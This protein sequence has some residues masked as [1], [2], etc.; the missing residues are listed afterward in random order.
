MN[1]ILITDDVPVIIAKMSDGDALI[2]N[3]LKSIFREH[4]YDFMQV[5]LNLNKHNIRGKK[6]YQLYVGCGQSINR[7]VIVILTEQENYLEKYGEK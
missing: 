4:I 1:D 2:S 6:I 5:I 3:I 7:F